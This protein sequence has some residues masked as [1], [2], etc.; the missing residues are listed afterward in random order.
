MVHLSGIYYEIG[1]R[2]LFDNISCVIPQAS[3]L[4]FIGPNGAGKTTLFRVL[5]GELQPLRGKVTKPRDFSIGYLPQ[6]EIVLDDQTVLQSALR[7]R[8]D[9]LSLAEKIESLRIQASEDEAALIR[10][11]E[12]EHQFEG[13]GG[14]ALEANAKAMLSGLGFNKEDFTRS[15]REFS[16][17]WR[18]RVYLA[19]LLLLNPDLL[20]LDEPTNHLDLSSLEWLE[21]YLSNFSGSI[22]VVSHDRYFI[23]R[24]A[25]EIYE[26]DGGRLEHYAGNYLF[27]E[28]QKAIHREQASARAKQ[29]AK[30]RLRQQEFIERFRY[31]ATKARQVQSRIKLLDRLDDVR[32]PEA[33]RSYT[34]KLT[35]PFASYH[36]VLHLRNV[37]VRYDGDWILE[38]I[39]LSIYRGQKI[40]VVGDNGAGKTTLTRM[41][42]GQLSPQRGQI[43]LGPR[44]AIGYYA[45]HQTDTLDLNATVYDE[46]AS[47]VADS[48]VPRIRDM[49]GVFGFHGDDVFKPVNVLSGGE[50]ARVSL[51]KILLS[52]VN[53][54]IM[55]EPTNHLDIA[56]KEALENA[57]ADYDG[58]V[59][60]IS[61]D[62]YFLDK[63]VHRVVE[64]KDKKLHEYDGNY[65]DYT[66]RRPQ[67][68]IQQP[69]AKVVKPIAGFKSKD[70]KRK[71]AEARQAVS[72][73]RNDLNE[74]IR[75]AEEK[76][77]DLERRKS[78]LEILL[79]QPETYKD[80]EKSASL[81]REYHQIKR[82]LEIY[83]SRWETVQ[84]EL[85]SLLLELNQ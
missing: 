24:I 55:D 79:G 11:G 27:Y 10:L 45:Q 26:L 62:R 7:G 85:D 70:E 39:S 76:I 84:Q 46:I 9:L 47:A 15:I 23:D 61:H 67:T 57:L 41:M 29:A 44:A 31:K 34:F 16:G 30:E 58:T 1:D 68:V 3:R 28:K 80:G 52:A 33:T 40:A 69:P 72:R 5:T 37:S 53:F 20:L 51:T 60:L 13:M 38:D 73:R 4:A 35:T 56:A 48:Q 66:S 25:R 2:I 83:L 22:V 75:Q 54:L 14:Y 64:V 77:D 12:L 49:L 81:T 6:E 59:I 8:K 42:V 32:V 71:A 18:M 63:L 17:G 65:T 74:S 78:E 82:D 43:V 36:E 19:R 21:G 50:K